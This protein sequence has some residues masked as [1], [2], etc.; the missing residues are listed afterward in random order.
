MFYYKL[1]LL[2][3][4]TLKRYNYFEKVQFQKNDKIKTKNIS[5]IYYYSA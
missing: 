3:L 5:S 1:F 2:L 4:I